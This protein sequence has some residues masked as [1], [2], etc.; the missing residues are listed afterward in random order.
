MCI[1]E[2][3]WILFSLFVSLVIKMCMGGAAVGQSVLMDFY[4]ADI[5]KFLHCSCVV[6][7]NGGNS[8]SF[9]EVS[10]P[11]YLECGSSITIRDNRDGIRHIINCFG[12]ATIGQLETGHTLAIILTRHFTDANAK[13]CYRLNIC[14]Y[15]MILY[16]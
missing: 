13:Y 5:Q 10:A 12:D 16:K 15:F 9:E 11:G 2:F 8:L 3:L 1:Y 7:I 4:N 14:K 6:H